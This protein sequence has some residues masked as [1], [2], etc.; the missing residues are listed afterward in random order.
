MSAFS[1]VSCLLE[2]VLFLL[3]HL[4]LP[5]RGNRTR[6][7]DSHLFVLSDTLETLDVKALGGKR[8]A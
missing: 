1:A 6:G 7:L 8:L 3:C 4:L 5:A 2:I